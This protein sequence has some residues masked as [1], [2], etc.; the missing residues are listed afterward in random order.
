[1]SIVLLVLLLTNFVYAVFAW[2]SEFFRNREWT[3]GKNDGPQKNRPAT[4]ASVFTEIKEADADTGENQHLKEKSQ[5][6]KQAERAPQQEDQV[7]DIDLEEN[8]AVNQVRLSHKP[9]APHQENSHAASPS[10]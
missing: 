1:M 10:S 4:A 7:D 3:S 6:S 8:L 5:E 9:S 2:Y